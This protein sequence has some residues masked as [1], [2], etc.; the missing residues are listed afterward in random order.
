M[1]INVVA[2]GKIKEKYLKLGIEEFSKRLSKY[3]KLSVNEIPDEKAPE[4]MSEKQAQMVRDKEGEKILSAV[5]DSSY[6]ITLEI[7]GNMLSSEELADKLENLAVTGKSDITFIIGG[8]IGLSKDVLERSNYALS[9]SKMT[10]PHQLMRVILLEQVYRSFRINKG[11][12][13]HK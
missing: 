11:E 6:V 9:F 10:F 2:V 1:N 5:K 12:P 4:N 7:G 8:S 3:C 13:Y